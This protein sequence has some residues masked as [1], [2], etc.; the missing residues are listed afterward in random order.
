MDVRF[1]LLTATL[2]VIASGAYALKRLASVAVEFQRVSRKSTA[3]YNCA[4]K[5]HG[6]IMKFNIT[7]SSSATYFIA[8]LTIL[9]VG[10]AKQAAAADVATTL[11][12]NANVSD[13]VT[14]PTD[15]TEADAAVGAYLLPLAL[16]CERHRNRILVN[17]Q[18]NV[19]DKLF[20][21]PSSMHEAQ[22]QTIQRNPLKA[23]IL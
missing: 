17:T 22:H 4:M 11:A 14:E 16:V 20:H 21:D 10:A 6:F 5:Q 9:A 13:F 15:I 8:A 19:S 23:C 3:M 7:R 18:P 2:V 12:T 1:V